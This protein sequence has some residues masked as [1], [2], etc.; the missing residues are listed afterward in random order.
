MCDTVDTNH[1]PYIANTQTNLINVLIKDYNHKLSSLITNRFGAKK[2]ENLTTL[3][4]TMSVTK[5]LTGGNRRLTIKNSSFIN[6]YT[7]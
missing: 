6:Y 5:S 1:F 3:I 2:N 7:I 4:S